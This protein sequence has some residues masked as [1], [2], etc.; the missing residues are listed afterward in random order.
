MILGIGV[1]LCSIE[2]IGRALSR[3]G[4][5]FLERV[6]TPEEQDYVQSLRGAVRVGACAKRWAAKEACAKALGTG[7]A[8]GVQLRD[9]SVGR[10]PLGAPVLSLSGEAASVLARRLPEGYRAELLLSMSDDPPLA[11]AQVLIQA[12][13]L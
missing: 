5:A 11:M 8:H 2:R 4:D 7:F 6:F 9:I 12:I 13:S 1:D 10:N 3:H